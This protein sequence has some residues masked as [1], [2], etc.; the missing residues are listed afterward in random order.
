MTIS[1]PLSQSEAISSLRFGDDSLSI[2][3]MRISDV[4]NVCAIENSIYDFP[5]TGGNFVDSLNAGYCGTV[6]RRTHDSIQTQVLS[7]IMAYAMTMKL[8]DGVHLLNISVARQFQGQGLGRAYLR[9]IVDCARSQ[10]TDGILLEVRPTNKAA[11]A[12]YLEQGFSQIG[13]R[14]GYYPSV[15]NQRED[16]LVFSLA[17]TS[18]LF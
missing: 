3:P 16:A 14:K 5:W 6:V 8:P 17:F 18:Q 9:T 15:H 10:N 12:L 13:V 7:P 2:N 4:E 1:M 11:I